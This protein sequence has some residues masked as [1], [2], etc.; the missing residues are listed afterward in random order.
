MCRLVV[1][2]KEEYLV[3]LELID[4]D[5]WLHCTVHSYG[6][7]VLDSMVDDWMD[8][9]EAL[10]WEGFTR[11]LACPEK[12]GFMK[13]TGWDLLTTTEEYGE[14]RGIYVWDL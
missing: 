4:S 6:P 8:I 7:H 9:E 10:R 11:V 1:L 13:H 14:P 2:D 3:E 5:V 12:T